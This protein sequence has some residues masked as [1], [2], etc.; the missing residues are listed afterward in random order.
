MRT[1]TKFSL[2]FGVY[3]LILAYVAGDLFLFNGPISKKIIAADPNTPEAIA[4]AKAKGVIARV[5]NHEI[6]R[7]QLDYAVQQRLWLSGKSISNISKEEQKLVTYA[8][9]GDLIDHELLR[10][11][12]KVNTSDLSVTEAEI[13]QRIKRFASKFES[14]TA[15]EAAMKSQGISNEEALRNKIAARIQQEK[16][17]ALRVDPLVKVTAEEIKTFYEE[18]KT[19]LAIPER[20][21]AR[22]IFISTLTKTAEEAKQPLEIALLTLKIG[23]KDFATLAREI[24]E[25]YSNKDSSGDLGWMSKQRLPADFTDPVFA[26]PL[27]EPTLIQTKIG[28]HL[29]EFLDRKPA[30]IRQLEEVTEEITKALSDT[31]RHQAVEDFKDALRQFEAHKI[32]IF[33]D[34]LH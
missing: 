13:N 33:H 1:F 23:S 21:R 11:K 24:S 18:H 6:T 28:W 14:R 29:I 4:A 19:Q 25:D 27:N 17:I 26:L 16:Y 31:K 15:L 9:L 22:H 20:I 2:R 10:V 34:Q 32:Q 5:F 8:A 7:S 30:Q 3:L 12:V